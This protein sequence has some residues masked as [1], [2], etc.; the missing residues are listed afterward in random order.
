MHSIALPRPKWIDLVEQGIA[1]L[2]TVFTSAGEGFIADIFDGTS[3]IPSDYYIG[4]GTSGTTAAKGDTTLGTESAESRVTATM[5]QPSADVNRAVGEITSSGSQTIQEA[6]LFTAST[7]G[8]LIV[9][10]D[11]TGIA[12]GSG[13][14]IE[15]TIDIEWT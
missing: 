13:D 1:M 4:W 15:F 7:S 2:A 11:F 5:T 12:L 10:G 3:T 9:H 14:S 8:I 6:G